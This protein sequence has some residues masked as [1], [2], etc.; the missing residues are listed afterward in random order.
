MSAS[1]WWA[2][3]NTFL[4]APSRQFYMH[5]EVKGIS[6]NEFQSNSEQDSAHSAVVLLEEVLLLL[7]I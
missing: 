1:V 3:E 6:L 5:A 4:A 7:N 2:E